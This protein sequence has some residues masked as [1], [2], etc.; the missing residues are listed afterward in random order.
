MKHSHHM[1]ARLVK[2]TV[3]LTTIVLSISG[4]AGWSQQMPIALYQLELGRLRPDQ[5]AGSKQPTTSPLIVASGTIEARGVAVVAEFGGRVMR[6]TADEGEN[7][8]RGQVLV[9]LDESDLAVQVVQ[10]QAGLQLAQ[11]E[12]VRAEARVRPE[13]I[14]IAQSAL[15][16]ALVQAQ[17]SWQ[18]WQDAVQTRDN[19]QEL[20]LRITEAQTALALAGRDVE[21]AEAELEAAKQS[22]DREKWGSVEYRIADK[23]VVAAEEALQ[24]A[25]TTQDGAQAKLDALQVI[26][27]RPLILE[28]EVHA[29]EAAYRMAEADVAVARAQLA[30]VQAPPLNEDVAMAKAKVHQAEATLHTLE[31]MRKRMALRA[32]CDGMIASRAVEPGEITAP[33]APLLTITDLS[34]VTLTVYVPET[35]I[36]R[37]GLGQEA[38]AAVDSYPGQGFVGRVIHIAD[39]AEFTPRN[40]QTKEERVNTVFAVKI[41][42]PNPEQRLKPGMPAD[43]LLQVE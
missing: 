7:V 5:I 1:W 34:E 6:V 25:R 38:I 24:A 40:V 27:N 17:G 4:C 42:L 19:P 36:G 26:R 20:Q 8:T 29:A 41:A 31:V 13:E 12:L 21:L 22:R 37:V 32:P 10:A 39:Q 28:A 33:G 14:A 43:A 9:E 11:A 18:Q 3:I 15:H 35:Q 30:A 2:C 23:R 16:Q